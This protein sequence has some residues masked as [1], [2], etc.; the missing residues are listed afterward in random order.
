MITGIDHVAVQV[1]DFERTVAAYEVIFGR[2]PNWRGGA[3]GWRH[4]WFQFDAMALDVVAA[5]GDGPGADAIRADTEK[6][7]EGLW[8]LGF[9]V[10]DVA[11]ALHRFVR[12]GLE[13]VPTTRR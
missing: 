11:Q 2:A 10:P 6:H 13:F 3:S 4:A 1:R 7:G 5:D 9:T 12:R 8:G